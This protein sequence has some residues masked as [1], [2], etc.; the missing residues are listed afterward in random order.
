MKTISTFNALHLGDNLVHLHFLRKMAQAYPE[1][2]FIHGAQDHHL[3]Q[4]Y[5]VWQDLEN[6]TVKS[7]AEVGQGSINAWRGAGGHWYAHPQRNDFVAYHLDW[8]RHLARTMGLESPIHCGRDMLFDYPAL[9]PPQLRY[10]LDFL[11]INSPPSSGQW[12][13]F[14]GAG[15]ARLARSLAEKYSVLTTAPCG[16]NIGCTQDVGGDITHIGMV[17]HRARCIIGC[18]TG[19]M[20]P[21][22]NQWNADTVALRVHLLDQERVDYIP[23]RTVHCNSLSLVPEILRDRGL[24]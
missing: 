1:I 11:I 3:A 5:P 17:S 22:L 20:W 18:V 4:L 15:F 13:G 2:H 10:P 23:E 8:F 7:I 24:L 14:D 6:L 21:C 12:Q 9:R 16:G 19:P